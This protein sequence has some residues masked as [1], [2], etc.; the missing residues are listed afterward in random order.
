MALC[1]IRASP[2]L[3]LLHVCGH[4]RFDSRTVAALG[5]ESWPLNQNAKNASFLKW[6]WAQAASFRPTKFGAD[7]W[8]TMMK[9]AGIRFFDFTTKHHEG[10]SMYDTQT[11]L[12]ECWQFD[13]AGSFDG[14][15]ACGAGDASAYALPLTCLTW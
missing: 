11:R 6:Y 8:M 10:F 14:V 3:A 4:A 15:G 2:S 7:E 12:H 9:A 13:P 5:P 1:L